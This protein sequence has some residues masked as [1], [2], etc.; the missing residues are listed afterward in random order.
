MGL[1]NLFTYLITVSVPVFLGFIISLLIS[2]N[3]G[4][5]FSAFS[6]GITVLS[7]IFVY[8]LAQK[9]NIQLDIHNCDYEDSKSLLLNDI[10]AGLLISI[11]ISIF[12]SILL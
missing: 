6:L 9:S 1:K 5:Y 11:P 10:F 8:S 12:L 7:L 3:G 2:G 4:I